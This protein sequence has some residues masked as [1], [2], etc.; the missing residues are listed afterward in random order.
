MSRAVADAFLPEPRTSS[1]ELDAVAPAVVA[2]S[3]RWLALD[4]FRF[5]AVLMMVQGHVFSTLLD[6]A[7]RAT[8]WFP[9][10][11][12]FHGFT[13][14][15]FLF[16]AGLAF[17]YTTFPRWHEHTSFG[18]AVSKR[19]KRYV[20]LLVLGYGLQLPTLSL[21]ELLALQE[22]PRLAQFLS[23]NVLQHIGVSLAFVQLLVGVLKRRDAVIAIVA[24][25]A[26]VSV[27][28]AP[29][30]WGLDVSG[31]PLWLRGYVNQADY[32]WFPLF[33]WA[34]FT[35]AGIVLAW[36]LFRAPSTESVSGRLAWPLLALSLA[37]M[38]VPVVIDRFG[39]FPWPPHSFWKANPL[40][41][42]W[43]FGNVLFVLALLCFAE[44]FAARRGWLDADDGPRVVR[45]LA[46]W[47]TLLAAESLVIYVAHLLILH[48][49]VIAP[50]VTR[51]GM[52]ET[53]S[54]GLFESSIATVL[55]MAVMIVA[56]KAWSSLRKQARAYTIVQLTIIGV[57]LLL[58]LTK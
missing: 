21:T 49:S 43:R 5:F 17:G 11:N 44:R 34:G 48:G 36:A 16:G 31:L 56:A 22:G 57:V 37:T 45:V 26:A 41:F 10:H 20:W 40:F 13:A 1:E 8:G 25:L 7:T 15:M 27:L 52:L 55:M 24:V 6:D 3:P 32:S 23:V 29:W 19:F 4:V 50:G 51:N 9:H 53:R 2:K 14:P 42:F 58:S 30:V 18:P 12:A 46:P 38:L 47:V 35:Y 28:A 33:P 54:L 39:P